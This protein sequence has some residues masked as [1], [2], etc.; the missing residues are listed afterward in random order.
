MGSCLP[1]RRRLGL[2]GPPGTL[3]LRKGAPL[4]SRWGG[5]ACAADVHRPGGPRRRCAS[6]AAPPGGLAPLPEGLDGQAALVVG[7]ELF[8]RVP[9]SCLGFLDV[10][11][12]VGVWLLNWRL[13]PM[14]LVTSSWLPACSSRCRAGSI[15]QAGNAMGAGDAE[16][17]WRE[18]RLTAQIGKPVHRMQGRPKVLCMQEATAGVDRQ[19]VVRQSLRRYTR[20]AES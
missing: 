2:R 13:M 11:F 15:K 6:P 1:G 3:E 5:Y 20:G 8:I 4:P 19:L 14:L 7:V 17:C 9:Q 12:L 18:Y 16:R 10:S